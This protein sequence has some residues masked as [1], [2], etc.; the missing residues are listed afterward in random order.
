[1]PTN[2]IP[3]LPA[4]IPV[5]PARLRPFFLMMKLAPM[6]RL[7]LT[8]RAK[9]FW[10]SVDID[11]CAPPLVR[12]SFPP[13]LPSS[14]HPQTLSS[15]S[16]FP[17]C[18]PLSHPSFATKYDPKPPKVQ[19][20]HVPHTQKSRWTRLFQFVKSKPDHGNLHHFLKSITE[21]DASTKLIV[22]LLTSPFLP[23]VVIQS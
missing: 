13:T 12:P 11:A 20:P 22:C 9:P 18:L 10:L 6:K 4:L 14:P 1:M 19:T 2:T 15:S 5:A 21:E 23:L 8:A 17:P 7:E 16:S 3:H